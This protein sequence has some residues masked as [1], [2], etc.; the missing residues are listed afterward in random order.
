MHARN[1][2]QRGYR[3]GKRKRTREGSPSRLSMHSCETCGKQCFASRHLAKLGAD[4]AAAGTR[5]RLYTCNGAWH[6]TSVPAETMAYY[7]EKDYL[8]GTHGEA[9]R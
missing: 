1:N 9:D 2:A 8:R 3:Y 6:M 5:I 4:R 7:R